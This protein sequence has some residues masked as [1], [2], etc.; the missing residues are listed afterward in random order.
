MTLSHARVARAIGGGGIDSLRFEPTAIEQPGPGE[1]LLRLK[2]ATLNY[3]DLLMI[4]GA[5]PGLAKEPDYVPLSCGAGEVLAV[6]EGVTRVKMGDRVSPLFSLGWLDGMMP[7][8][9][10]LGGSADGVAR[11]HAVFP[12]DSLVINPD[13]LGDLDA[14]TLACAGLTA[15]N[16]L[17]RDRELKSSDLVLVQGT[18]GV[19]I[20]A[21]QWAKAAGARVAV[22]SSSDAKL[23]RAKALGADLQINYRTHPDWPAQ[24][25][26]INGGKGADVIVEN[27]GQSGMAMAA[28]AI[29]P[30]G[31][32]SAVGRLDGGSGWDAQ[33]LNGV[34]IARITV[35]NRVQHEAML[36]FAAK[37]GI[38]PVVDAVYELERLGDAF[39][40]VKS[41]QFLGKIA[42]SLV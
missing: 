22:T 27:V 8:M 26:A 16:A 2:A 10:M 31:M 29:E 40:H 17:F 4:E 19:A 1:A 36:A 3:R 13:S 5:L 32:I 24:L 18:G 33:P 38:R 9:A 15:W 39:R 21:L 35:G 28:S 41:G 34:Q 20:A 42:I 11:T 30:G 23:A 6:G 14:A 12:A 37:H 7:S 25:R